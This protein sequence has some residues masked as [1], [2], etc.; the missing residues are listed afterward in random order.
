[1]KCSRVSGRRREIARKV[2]DHRWRS[3]D[4]LPVEVVLPAVLKLQRRLVLREV[5]QVHSNLCRSLTHVALN[6]VCEPISPLVEKTLDYLCKPQQPN[7]PISPHRCCRVSWLCHPPA[8]CRSFR[9]LSGS[10][11]YNP[12]C[13]TLLS[14]R[15]VTNVRAAQELAAHRR[16]PGSSELTPQIADDPYYG[17]VRSPSHVKLNRRAADI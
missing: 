17:L 3:L 6:H 15:S 16:L 12:H 5:H 2:D 14:A 11:R 13:A 9:P 8:A 10:E 4:R 7:R 1:M